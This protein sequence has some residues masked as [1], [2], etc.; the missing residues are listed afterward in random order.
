MLC[1]ILGYKHYIG[2][3]YNQDDNL[4]RD[5]HIDRIYDTYIDEDQLKDVG[6]KIENE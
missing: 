2:T 4:L 1:L 6:I 3:P 5:L